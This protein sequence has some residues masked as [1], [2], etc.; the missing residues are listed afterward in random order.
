MPVESEVDGKVILGIANSIQNAVELA[1][2]KDP[3]MVRS[4]EFKQKCE[5]AVEAFKAVHSGRF[6]P[7]Q[8]YF[9]KFL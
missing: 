8:N 9:L 5:K 6:F 7:N 1:V 4:P 2:G 3:I